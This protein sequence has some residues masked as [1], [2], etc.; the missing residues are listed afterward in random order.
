MDSA[1]C[2]VSSCSRL[3]VILGPILVGIIGGA[4]SGLLALF[5]VVPLFRNMAETYESYPSLKSPWLATNLDLPGWLLA[6]SFVIGLIAPFAM[7]IATVWLVRS[8]DVWS[9]LSA[10]LSTAMASTIASV[11][12][13]RGGRL[14]SGKG[15]LALMPA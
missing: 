2:T 4:L 6:I 8:R 9:D 10:G 15:R 7:G 11:G 1:A 14:A 13:L 5:A 3:R 12:P